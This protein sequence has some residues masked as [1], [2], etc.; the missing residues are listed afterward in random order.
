MK[1]KNPKIKILIV[2]DEK[3]I[4]WTLE[5]ALAN[6][7]YEIRT[8][9]SG[10]KAFERL[11]TESFDLVITDLKLPKIDGF[12]VARVAKTFFPN[13]LIIMISA[14]SNPVIEKSL[15]ETVIDYFIEKPFDLRYITTLIK[16]IIENKFVK[17]S[18]MGEITQSI[19]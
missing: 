8:V 19:E 9:F 12:D 3:L 6:F 4:N 2:E 17:T 10:E 15:R 13:I 16:N 14:E 18:S 1:Q 5:N 7:G 11:Y